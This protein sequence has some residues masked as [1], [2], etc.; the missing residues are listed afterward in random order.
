MLNNFASPADELASL[1]AAPGEDLAFLREVLKAALDQV[2]GVEAVNGFEELQESLKE[3]SPCEEAQAVARAYAEAKKAVIVFEQKKLSEDA[4]ALLANLAFITG[5]HRGPRN[6]VIQLKAEANAQGA[7]D[8][9]IMS[10]DIL[11]AKISSGEIKG[12]FVFGE[13]AADSDLDS[14][15]FL[16][17]QD[18]QMTATAAKAEVVLP[19]SSFAEV[20]GTF[21]NAVGE[22]QIL[23]KAVPAAVEYTNFEQIALLAEQAGEPLPY[24][25]LEEV[26]RA[27]EKDRYTA[28]KAEEKL[29]VVQGDV[30]LRQEQPSTNILYNSLIEYAKK[31]GIA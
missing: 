20:D 22:V 11:R 26:Q 6:G 19:A 2:S 4:A 28:A 3:I 24:R 16:A 8:L 14:L 27:I 13:D 31:E 23:N 1:K 17:V 18:L 30:L 5:H 12:L 29:A 7:A 15:E 9:G 10:G 21:T 25:N